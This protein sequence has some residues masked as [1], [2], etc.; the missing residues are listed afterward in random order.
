[1]M[2]MHW[3]SAVCLL[4]ELTGKHAAQVLREAADGRGRRGRRVVTGVLTQHG[5]HVAQVVPA[6]L[7]GMHAVGLVVALV[8]VLAVA[9]PVL[10]H[11]G[12]RHDC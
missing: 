7:T 4:L 6:R 8:Q 5:K 12:G 2:M 11:R 1:M 10:P 9:L 3:R